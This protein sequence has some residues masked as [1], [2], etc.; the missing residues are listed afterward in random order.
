[1]GKA[2]ARELLGVSHDASLRE[3]RGAYRRLAI[4]WHPDNC[5]GDRRDSARKF[6][7]L[8][9][10]YQALARSYGRRFSAADFARMDPRFGGS[11]SPGGYIWGGPPVRQRQS[12]ARWNETRAFVCLWVF[13]MVLGL[14]GA[15]FML[16]SGAIGDD[17]TGDLLKLQAV[18]ILIY[19]AIVAGV[20]VLIPL[21]RKAVEMTIRLGF[22]MLP[23]LG[24]RRTGAEDSNADR[25]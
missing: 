1:M 11:A 8:T 23:A 22:R 2:E 21:T 17:S 19:V 12:L 13:A 20:V 3:I 25:Q 9:Q 5:P 4:Q 16:A 24:V 10:A 6:R 7:R 14:A 15:T 18:A